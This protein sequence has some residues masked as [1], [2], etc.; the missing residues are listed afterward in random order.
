MEPKP[1]VFPIFKFLNRLFEDRPAIPKDNFVL[2]EKAKTRKRIKK[3]SKAKK[4]R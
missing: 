1:L 3:A 2:S 4:R